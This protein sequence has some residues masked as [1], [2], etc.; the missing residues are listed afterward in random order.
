MA[1]R[2]RANGD[3]LCAAMH[4]KRDDDLR[5]VDDHQHYVL[6]VDWRILVTE[7]M[8]PDPANPGRGGHKVH[9]QWWWLGGVPADA[10]LEQR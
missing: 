1:V 10:V 5:Y 9:G 7:P 3:V 8:E 2:I 4:E 6:S